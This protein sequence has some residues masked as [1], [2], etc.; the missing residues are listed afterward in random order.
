MSNDGGEGAIGGGD[1]VRGGVGVPGSERVRRCFFS[2][3]GDDG[4]V[5]A[6]LTTP[7]VR[8]AL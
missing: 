6:V 2:G 8:P 3:R 4:A 5:T 7:D 1:G